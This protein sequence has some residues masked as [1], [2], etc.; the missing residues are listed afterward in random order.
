V[1]SGAVLLVLLAGPVAPGSG[2]VRLSGVLAEQ[3]GRLVADRLGVSSGAVSAFDPSSLPVRERWRTAVDVRHAVA[4]VT[5]GVSHALGVDLAQSPLP[6]HELVGDRAVPP[7]RRNYL[8]PAD[9]RELPLGCWVEAGPYSRS[10][11]LARGVAGAAGTAGFLR[12]NARSYLAVYE[13]RGGAMWRL[14]TTGRRAHHGLVHEGTAATVAAARDDGRRAVAERFPDAARMVGPE[15]IG[16]VLSPAL[17]WRPMV[18]GR[19]DRTLQRVFDERVSA[20]VAPG[21]GGAMGD[22]GERRRHA[23]PGPPD[24]R[25]G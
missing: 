13:T 4:A 21:P 24:R 6:R 3:A 11:W 18:D 22:V 7:G 25:P 5:A 2:R 1:G 19:D 17:G 23:A 9:V 14:E 15:R 16:R 12:L 10:E 20:V 8:A